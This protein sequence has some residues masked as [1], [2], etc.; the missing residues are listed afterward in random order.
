MI[1]ITKDELPIFSS[2]PRRRSNASNTDIGRV[3]GRKS[4]WSNTIE[5]S[6]KIFR[7]QSWTG[8][9]QK[10][11]PRRPAPPPPAQSAKYPTTVS[12][13]P[14]SPP[15]PLYAEVNKSRPAVRSD[16]P[17]YYLAGECDQ[18]WF[19]NPGM[20]ETYWNN[21]KSAFYAT[22]LPNF[23]YIVHHNISSYLVART[24]RVF[25]AQLKGHYK[26]N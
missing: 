24:L 22:C 18:H 23:P 8:V 3:T 12:N 5:R 7:P 9:L 25:H 14:T 26:L 2:T 13:L 4:L 6:S 17:T 10:L 21:T 20:S 1:S 11:V 19:D 16:S 15:A